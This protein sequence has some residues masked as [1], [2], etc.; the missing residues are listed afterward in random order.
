MNYKDELIEKLKKYTKDDIIMST[1]AIRQ[2]MI[3]PVT[4]E[5]IIENLLNPKRLSYALK[6]PAERRGEEKFACYFGYSRRLCHCYI[7][8]I[9]AKVLVVTSYIINRRWQKEVEKHAKL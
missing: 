8:V 7:I 1:H 4:I 9:N 6:E 3:R 5:N 2:T